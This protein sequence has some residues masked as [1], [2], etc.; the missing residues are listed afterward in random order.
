MTQLSVSA[1]YPPSRTH[2]PNTALLSSQIRVK[3][4]EKNPSHLLFTPIQRY[5]VSYIKTHGFLRRIS[6]VTNVGGRERQTLGKGLREITVQREWQ[7]LRRA[8]RR[9]VAGAWIDKGS[10]SWHLW[11][12]TP[13]NTTLRQFINSFAQHCPTEI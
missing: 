11:E 10:A 12:D 2:S 8:G 6:T 1:P 9:Q 7:D 13:T 4:P 5:V 3:A